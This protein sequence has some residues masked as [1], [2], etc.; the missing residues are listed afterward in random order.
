MPR[1]E[2]TLLQIKD[3]IN[4]TSEYKLLVG[5]L[6]LNLLLKLLFIESKDISHDEPFTI[7]HANAS[8]NDLWIMLAT[9]P[10]PPLFFILLHCWVKI[11]GITTY[12]VRFLPVIFSSLTVIPLFKLSKYYGKNIVAVLVVLLFT[13]SDANMACA[14]DARTYSLFGFLSLLSTFFLFKIIFNNHINFINF[15]TLGITYFLMLYSH[16]IGFIVGIVH[17]IIIGINYKKVTKKILIGLLVSGVIALLFYAHYIP[18]FYQS[19]FSTTSKGTVNPPPSPEAIYGMLRYYMNAPL[20]AVISLVGFG[21][22]LTISIKTKQLQNISLL[23][24]FVTLYF[25][26]YF[27][28]GLV[29]LFV[30]RYILFISPIYYLIVIVGFLH[31]SKNNYLRTIPTLILLIG[32][33]TQLDLKSDNKRYIKSIVEIIQ[34]KE[35]K[36]TAIIMCP[37]WTNHRFTYYYDT[38][39][40]KAHQNFDEKLHQKNIYSINSLNELNHLDLDQFEN[41]I[42]LDGWAEVVDPEFKILHSLEKSF[43]KE[44]ENYDFKGYRIWNFIPKER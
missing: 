27:L 12:S 22:F 38:S 32:M 11:F 5:F 34:L 35:K 9:E 41:I 18:L 39:I 6:A 3:F 25:G 14:H 43:E 29:P 2:K 4:K 40:F 24:L 15:V 42:Y 10:N 7:F 23:T 26:M 8:W 1:F 31:L 33:S 30:D 17:V 44:Y 19:F 28:S 13:L 20:F 16:H 36:N 37:K 21:A